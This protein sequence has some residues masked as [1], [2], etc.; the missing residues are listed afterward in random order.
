MK[1]WPLPRP[2]C[3]AGGARPSTQKSVSRS[4]KRA[5]ARS[6]IRAAIDAPVSVRP[7]SVRALVAR[8]TWSRGADG[9]QAHHAPHALVHLRRG[10]LSKQ[11]VDGLEWALQQPSPLQVGRNEPLL[12]G[13]C[14][15][16]PE[17]VHA[18]RAGLPAAALVVRCMPACGCW[19]GIQR[20]APVHLLV[21]IVPGELPQALQKA[22]D[23]DR[24]TP[25]AAGAGL[26]L[27]ANTR[28]TKSAWRCCRLPCTSSN[29]A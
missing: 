7:A 14:R 15:A 12:C 20:E 13:C 27:G 4:Q 21:S 6:A 25:L 2:R 5:T 23:H 9:G 8:R 19:Q 29:C 26:P 10:R 17:V 28:P 3:Q 18:V 16:S 1:G 24:Y 22:C 11:D